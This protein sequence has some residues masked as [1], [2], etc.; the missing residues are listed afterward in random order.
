[1]NFLSTLLL[2]SWLIAYWQGGQRS[3][4]IT[5]NF[6]STLLLWGWLIAHW[7]VGQRRKEV[8]RSRSGAEQ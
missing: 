1:M 4:A 2:W 3:E 8:I 6:V 5:M 7:K